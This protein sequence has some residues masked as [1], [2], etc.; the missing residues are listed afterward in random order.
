V[1]MDFD[2]KDLDILI[3]CVD[4]QLTRYDETWGDAA[5]RREHKIKTTDA[6]YQ[7]QAE[8]RAKAGD[9]LKRLEVE[10]GF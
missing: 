8:S 10:R 6:F 2:R 3:T 1:T 7:A 5:W 9:L 4:R